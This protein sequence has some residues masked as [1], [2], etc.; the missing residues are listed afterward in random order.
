MKRN[1]II[2]AVLVIIT[3]VL[4]WRSQPDQV[5]KRRSKDLIGMA[6][7]VSVGPGIFDLNRLKILLADEVALEIEQVSKD[8]K[9]VAEAQVISAYQWL[10]ENVKRSSFEIVEFVGID[11]D[12][13]QATIKARVE[14][15]IE[16]ENI[17]SM[18]GEYLVTFV[19]RK[20]A[21]GDW[22]LAELI[23]E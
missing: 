2:L 8:R 13:S 5:L 4:I 12:G 3:G 6:N 19:W 22:V 11:I 21:R 20:D 17:R 14:G 18:D 9:V 10:G 1:L 23:L 15:V 16:T 7:S